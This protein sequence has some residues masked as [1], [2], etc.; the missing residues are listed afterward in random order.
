MISIIKLLIM[1]YTHRKWWVKNNV[2]HRRLTV[3][4][5]CHENSGKWFTICDRCGCFMKYK[6]RFDLVECERWDNQNK[7]NSTEDVDVK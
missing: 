2:Y 4:R 7:Y 5:T 6:C 3:C 1:C